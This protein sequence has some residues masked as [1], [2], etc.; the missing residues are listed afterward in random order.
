MMKSLVCGNACAQILDALRESP[1]SNDHSAFLSKY[2]SP[3]IHI[4]LVRSNPECADEIMCEL[5]EDSAEPIVEVF[6]RAGIVL[7]SVHDSDVING[8]AKKEIKTADVVVCCVNAVEPDKLHLDAF[9]ALYQDAFCRKKTLL[10]V[11]GLDT[12]LT[13]CEDPCNEYLDYR[14][15]VEDI[16]DGYGVHDISDSLYVLSVSAPAFF[17]SLSD[18]VDNEPLICSK[19]RAQ[20]EILVNYVRG[21]LQKK[22]DA[23]DSAQ[24]DQ[25]H[26]E[27]QRL[28]EAIRKEVS[29]ANRRLA[30]VEKDAQSNLDHRF[31]AGKLKV[32]EIIALTENDMSDVLTGIVNDYLVSQE[33]NW[34]LIEKKLNGKKP[35]AH[36]G[37]K[38][39]QAELKKS[40]KRA[41][42]SDGMIQ[43][44]KKAVEIAE[45]TGRPV[46]VG[47]AFNWKKFHFEEKIS[48][49]G[50]KGTALHNALT[51]MFGKKAG[52]AAELIGK[53][54]GAALK[55]L[56]VILLSVGLYRI[57]K[58]DCNDKENRQKREKLRQR[59]SALLSGF[60]SEIR[61]YIAEDRAERTKEVQNCCTIGN[62]ENNDAALEAM[63]HELS[64][65]LA[66][67]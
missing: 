43:G 1:H 30:K 66:M 11:V 19:Y 22:H 47:K 53:G 16:L 51:K 60:F 64:R 9:C 2:Q 5:S 10:A 44:G 14:C 63:L 59:L 29:R 13:G 50:G 23:R 28:T 67:L 45:K 48:K 33:K 12:R 55:G 39:S 37:D 8:L 42:L 61:S 27:K 21:Y 58:D 40:K 7:D 46:V 25:E 20:A 31:S 56:D 4:T 65:A 18:A 38:F 57:W 26:L 6:E 36:I 3:E 54:A 32:K 41:H 15:D 49:P 52:P 35:S 62:C 24:L 17:R 34:P